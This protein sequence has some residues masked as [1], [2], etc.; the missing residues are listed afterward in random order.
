MREDSVAVRAARDPTVT[1]VLQPL[2][3]QG[4]ALPDRVAGGLA[5]VTGAHPVAETL[6]VTVG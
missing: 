5:L 6:G 3:E 4:A 2:R 1:D